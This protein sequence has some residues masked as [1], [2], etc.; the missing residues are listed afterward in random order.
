MQLAFY[1][2]AG[3]IVDKI[4]DIWTGGPYSHVELVI[5]N[6]CHSSSG[7]DHGVRSKVI[8]FKPDNWDIYELNDELQIDI[9]F[10]VEWFRLHDGQKYNYLGL[11]GFVVP[12]R[13][14]EHD[15]TRWFCSQAVAKALKIERSWTLSP[16]TLF[17]YM[18]PNMVYIKP[19]V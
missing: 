11:F 15:L 10:A 16:N 5:D 17:D 8:D 6:I 7:R 18:R 9:A 1:K 14:E 2:G 13:T 12:W 4:V 19:A 3:T